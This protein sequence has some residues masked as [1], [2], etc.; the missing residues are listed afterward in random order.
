MEGTSGARQL[1][2]L[3]RTDDQLRA[4][5]RDVRSVLNNDAVSGSLHNSLQAVPSALITELRNNIDRMLLVKPSA[6]D[7]KE[8]DGAIDRENN[9]KQDSCAAETQHCPITTLVNKGTKQGQK[10]ALGKRQH[11]DSLPT[12]SEG[13]PRKQQR[14][15]P[16]QQR[17]LTS[18]R[19]DIDPQTPDTT[20]I[21]NT[22][23]KM[24]MAEFSEVSLLLNTLGTIPKD[25][26]P[27]AEIKNGAMLPVKHIPQIR[28]RE[29]EKNVV[30]I[31]S[32]FVTLKFHSMKGRRGLKRVAG[33]QRLAR[34]TWPRED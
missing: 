22:S 34:Q 15:V 10:I 25:A 3:L 4:L 5:F 31:H 12:D 16:A 1:D 29:K 24:H 18:E 32:A 2:M 7:T 17:V 20:V 14:V 26:P 11:G 9:T 21:P 27:S 33:G 8:V 28:N 19:K 6:L 13:P 23:A 30:P